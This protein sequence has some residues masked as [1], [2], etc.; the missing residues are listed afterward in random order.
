MKNIGQ[1]PREMC[2]RTSFLLLVPHQNW[3]ANAVF[4]LTLFPNWYCCCC[5]SVVFLRWLAP[6]L[7][8]R[9]S[10]IHCESCVCVSA[11]FAP[12]S[13]LDSIWFSVFFEIILPANSMFLFSLSVRMYWVCLS[14]FCVRLGCDSTKSKQ[15]Q[16]EQSFCLNQVFWLDKLK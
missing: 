6:H 16:S 13:P 12:D 7:H 8:Q 9:T 10:S 2:T 3:L 11:N 14:I 5:C 1:E 4:F 15:N